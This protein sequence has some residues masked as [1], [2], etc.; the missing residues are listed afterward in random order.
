MPWG[1]IGG[2][3]FR[4]RRCCPTTLAARTTP[5][6]ETDAVATSN[7]C[8]LVV[9]WTVHLPDGVTT[10]MTFI[11]GTPSLRCSFAARPLTVWAWGTVHV[12]IGIHNSGQGTPRPAKLS[13]HRSP[14]LSMTDVNN[15]HLYLTQTP[16]V[17][18]AWCPSFCSVDRSIDP[19]VSD[20]GWGQLLV[21]VRCRGGGVGVTGGIVVV[22]CPEMVWLTFGGWFDRTDSY[23][24]SAAV[25]GAQKCVV[26]SSQDP[27]Q[28]RTFGGV[29][30]PERRG[31]Q[32]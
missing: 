26:G 30:D 14:S 1:R 8:E 12:T 7:G 21:R 18:A 27:V 32:W 24:I 31:H 6:V 10:F 4:R 11:P 17:R 25:F 9:P 13:P 5:I 2:L 3:Q 16:N 22:V 15:K 23:A 20:R 28:R 29:G 19:S